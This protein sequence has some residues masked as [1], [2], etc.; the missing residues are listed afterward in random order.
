M[1]LQKIPLQLQARWWAESPDS[2]WEANHLAEKEIA[3][4]AGGVVATAGQTIEERPFSFSEQL[5]AW[6]LRFEI[7]PIAGVWASLREVH[8]KLRD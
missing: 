6:Q 5:V 4:E 2:L 1:L 7:V 3:A 8:R